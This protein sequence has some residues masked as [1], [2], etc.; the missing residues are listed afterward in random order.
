MKKIIILFAAMVLVSCQTAPADVTMRVL[1][2]RDKRVIGFGEMVREIKGADVIL[3]GETHTSVGD[4]KAQ[5][6]VIKA[7]HASNATFAIGLEMFRADNQGALDRWVSGRMPLESFLPVYY[8]N[9]S[10]PW[11]LYRD[12]FLYARRMRIPMAGLNI[13]PRISNAVFA[14]GFGSLTPAEKK[15]LPG[16]I[17]CTVDKEYRRFIHEAYQFHMGGGGGSFYDFCQA[18]MLWDSVMAWR[19]VNYLRTRPGMKMVVLT[20]EGHAWKRGIP[21]QIRQRSDYSVEVVLPEMP[22]G[23]PVR[24]ITAKDADYILMR[25]R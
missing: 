2:V 8:K 18:Q 9:W 6:A 14:H 7:L 24:D 13:P 11:P 15:E 25:G 3:L 20:G 12:I 19:I 10:A 5:L 16:G 22:N 1:R 17:S 4:H 21:D 23:K